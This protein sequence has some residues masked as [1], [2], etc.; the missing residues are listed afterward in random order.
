[1]DSLP[2][3]Y[4]AK[5]S[6]SL[7]DAFVNMLVLLIVPRVLGPVGFGNFHYIRD[8]FQ[9]LIGFLDLNLCSAH[10]NYASRKTNSYLATSIYMVY[11]L[12]VGIILL[13][14]CFLLIKFTNVKE[15]FF[16]DQ[17]LF[18]IMLGGILV[19]AGYIFQAIM[20]LSDSKG[21]TVGFEKRAIIII[22]TCASIFV[23]I[24]WFDVLSLTTFFIYRISVFVIL[25]I[26]C[27]FYI[28]RSLLLIT[29]MRNPFKEKE[30]RKTLA[31]FYNFSHPLVVLSIFGLLAGFLDRWLLQ[32]INGSAAQGYFSLGLVLSTVVGVFLTPFSPLLM[33]AIALADE[34]N[35]TKQLLS[36]FKIVRS[37]YLL[38]TFL[39]IFLAFHVEILIRL[40]GGQS[41]VEAKWTIFVMLLT[42]MHVVYGQFCGSTLIALRQTAIYRN[43][44]VVSSLIGILV[45]YLLL[46]PKLFII[47]GLGLGSL[48]LAIK[49]L[50]TQ[51]I[52][53]NIQLYYVCKYLGDS[54]KSHLQFQI[55]L[56]ILFGLF[57]IVDKLIL[58]NVFALWFTELPIFLVPIFSFFIWV[59]SLI[60]LMIKFKKVFEKFGINVDLFITIVHRFSK[61]RV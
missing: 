43:I 61:Y 24:W 16:P 49:I 5:L 47:T 35:N 51:I 23:L 34:E 57:G 12:F 10:S 18:Y 9:N 56:T 31:I 50:I 13:C 25:I 4:F 37:L 22:T 52:V 38:A 29:N 26:S 2:H 46:A 48:G 33:Q 40:V 6:K 11:I 42:S 54:F 60:F 41:F 20:S 30:S 14:I 39:S 15:F 8:V 32:M 19:Y 3:R 59:L 58:S 28:N 27:F 44:A 55:V 7:V 21:L 53:V 1:M 45:T 17:N 36:S